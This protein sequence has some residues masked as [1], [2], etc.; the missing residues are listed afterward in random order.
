MT[1]PPRILLVRLSA[2]GDVLLT[3]P[4]LRALR[5]RHPDAEIQ[6]CTRPAFAPLLADHPALNGLVLFEPRDESLGEL[7][8]RIRAGRFTHLLDLHG[9]PRTR[10]LRLLAPGPW[11]GYSKR[12]LARAVLIR[13]KR[14][15]YR[16]AVP[17]P[18]RFF[19][20]ARGLDVRPDGGPP[21]FHLAD[22]ARERAAA[23]L[24]RHGL[25]AERPLVTLAPGA[26]H[27]T[28]RWPPEHWQALARALTTGGHD[29]LVVGG[30]DDV[31]VGDAVAQAAG[32]RA[33]SAA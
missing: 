6:Y 15:V 17:E 21:D 22:A 11:R 3:T 26:A 7:A 4:L 24:A 18:E 14:D 9:V 5:R 2:M 33:R 10:L 12:R 8:H 28:K 27:V 23:W 30:A 20:A 31:A 13:W 25:G 1:A 29:V 32:G 16:D 19:E